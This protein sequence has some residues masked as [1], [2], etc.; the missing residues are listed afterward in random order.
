[1]IGANLAAREFLV[2]VAFAFPMANGQ[3]PFG[4]VSSQ[5]LES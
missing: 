3:G 4:F 1:M 5:Q 2:V